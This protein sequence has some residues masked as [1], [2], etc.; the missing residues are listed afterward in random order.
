M[1]ND[2]KDK[3]AEILYDKKSLKEWVAKEKQSQGQ[4]I[5]DCLIKTSKELDI[6]KR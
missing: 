3:S 4:K 2:S 6:I 5:K 1:S